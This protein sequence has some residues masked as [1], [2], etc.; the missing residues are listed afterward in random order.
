MIRDTLITEIQSE[1]V[2][3]DDGLFYFWPTKKGAL[4]SDE[5]RAIADELDKKNKEWKEKLIEVMDKK[6]DD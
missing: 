2:A 6:I 1:L 4:S 5:L 3:L